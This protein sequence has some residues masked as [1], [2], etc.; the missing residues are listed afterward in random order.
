MT[1]RHPLKN[2]TGSLRWDQLNEAK[3]EKFKS[4]HDSPNP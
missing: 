2:G 1:P 4:E 3:S